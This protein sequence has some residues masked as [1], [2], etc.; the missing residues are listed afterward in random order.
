M[1]IPRR[2]GDYLTIPRKLVWLAAAAALV[3]LIIV[4]LVGRSMIEHEAKVA[5]DSVGD[6]Q[7]QLSSMRQ[8]HERLLKEQAFME[9]SR[10]VD[11]TSVLES[12][13]A[14]AELQEELNRV[15]GQLAFYQRI[16]SPEDQVK[17][18]YVDDLQLRPMDD[19]SGYGFRLTLAQ[20]MKNQPFVKGKVQIRV[21]SSSDEDAQSWSVKL[22]ADEIA[23]G[24]RYFQII[25]G[26]FSLPENAKPGVLEISVEP[27]T[28][29]RG[30]VSRQWG[31]SE[32]I[33]AVPSQTK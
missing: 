24:F 16:V 8:A 11:Q 31:W 14:L 29:N 6:M 23:F 2:S 26:S 25:E 20:S 12:Q 33:A 17:G 3:L 7:Q 21:K 22:S 15:N 30:G 19:K 32:L 28:R 4:F 13:H 27:T 5:I 9:S 1:L 10:M 18:L